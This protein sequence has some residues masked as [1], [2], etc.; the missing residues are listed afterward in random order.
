MSAPPGGIIHGRMYVDFADPATVPSESGI[1]VHV[2]IGSGNIDPDLGTFLMNV[3]SRFPRLTQPKVPGLQP[4]VSQAPEIPVRPDSSL[5]D[6]K[7][8]VPSHVE[9]TN[10]L[11]N[12]CLMQRAGFDVGTYLGR[13]SFEFRVR[14]IDEPPDL[15]T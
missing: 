14:G 11:G 15:A 9:Q 5:L 4:G 7:L 8:Q 6:F 12:I 2:W 13:A 1:Y 10:Y 3:D